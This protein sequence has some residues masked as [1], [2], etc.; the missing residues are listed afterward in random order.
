MKWVKGEI[1]QFAEAFRR[2]V[3]FEQQRFQLIAGALQC[4]MGQCKIV[5]HAGLVGGWDH[6]LPSPS[7]L[8][9]SFSPL[10]N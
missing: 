6:E 10:P 5:R 4:V 3:F 9:P 1:E 8:L 7:L 2:K